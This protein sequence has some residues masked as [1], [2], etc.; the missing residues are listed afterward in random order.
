[1]IR[2]YASCLLVFLAG[3]AVF[4]AASHEFPN[5]A[6]PRQVF[7]DAIQSYVTLLPSVPS[8]SPKPWLVYPTNST[9]WVGGFATA[10]GVP[11]SSQISEYFINGTSRPVV[12]LH[13]LILNSILPDPIKPL[14]KI[15][16]SENSTLAFFDTNNKTQTTETK[17]ITFPG[18]SIQYLA[19][20]S[21][22]RIW[23]SLLGPAGQSDMRM[24]NPSNHSNQTYQIPTNDAI[25]QGITVASDNTI[26]FAE[27]GSKK[28]GHLLP[29]SGQ[30]PTEF[31]PPTSLNLAAPIQVAV[32]E[33]G[34]VWF[35]DHGSNQFGELNPHPQTPT[36]KV[37][38]I[39]YCPDN[40]LYGLPNSIFVDASNTIWFSEHIA[41]RVGHYNPSSGV[42]TEYSVPGSNFPLM[43]W[44]MPGPYNLVWF[45][46][47][48][49]GQIGY[50]NAS[51]PVAFSMTGVP[52]AISVQRGS[53]QR[54]PIVGTST[55]S[56]L[57]S[58]N[59]SALSQDANGYTP[60]VYSSSQLNTT[61]GRSV[62][63]T[64]IQ[65]FA[66]WNASLGQR[67]MAVTAFDSKVSLSM[68]VQVTVVSSSFPYVAL[69]LS[70]FVALGGGTSGIMSLLKP[71]KKS[72]GNLKG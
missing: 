13:N 57:L 3:I 70:S 51:L 26:W 35:T 40:C 31:T 15:W 14:T 4:N 34:N 6:S 50:V 63:S 32:D 21:Q 71:K 17:A 49:L 29:E 5:S 45:V 11:P 2:S 20:D 65:I 60:F 38:P 39:G 56:E 27:A 25:V 46:S 67:V 33:S 36:W 43:W 23:M 18:E 47:Y 54:V 42:L 41:G 10:Q 72:S 52:P 64:S 44:A 48:G 19:S 22:N 28:I 30:T 55:G 66:A 62:Y 58:F 8:G 53:Y 16:F 1:M 37:F 59:S 9:I 7:Q 24:Y 69:G 61:V 12:T 68:F